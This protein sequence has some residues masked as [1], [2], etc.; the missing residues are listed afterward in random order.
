L[1]VIAASTAVWVFILIPLAIVW[2]LAI[3]DIVRRHLPLAQ[4]AGWILLVVL[5]PVIG[6]LVYF[7]LRKPT[8]EE[9]L[10]AQ[11]AAAEERDDPTS[12]HQRLPG[13]E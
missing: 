8:E 13:E 12:V 4:T 1:T 2:A 6:T 7:L 3:V 5:L 10:G 11:E 9:I